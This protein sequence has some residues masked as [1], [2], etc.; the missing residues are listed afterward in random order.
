MVL[1]NGVLVLIIYID[2]WEKE[3]DYNP[4]KYKT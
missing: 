3:M 4:K 1:L 2:T